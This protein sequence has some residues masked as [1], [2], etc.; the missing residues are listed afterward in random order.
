MCKIYASWFLKVQ[1]YE[2]G[3]QKMEVKN[4][5]SHIAKKLPKNK[6][7]LL[8]KKWNTLYPEYIIEQLKILSRTIRPWKFLETKV[9]ML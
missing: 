4:R 6:I 8:L 5:K 3:K 9:G 1:R 7:I 2:V